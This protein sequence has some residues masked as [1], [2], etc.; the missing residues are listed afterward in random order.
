MENQF[1][2][3]FAIINS[4]YSEEVMDA[5]KEC[6]ATGGTI[7]NARGTANTEIEKFFGI[8]ISSEKEVVM[9]IIPKK[10]KE[11][12]LKVIYEKVGLDTPGQGIA[13]TLPVDDVVG[14]NK[15]I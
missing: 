3:V 1:E 10:I 11:A 7:L 6:G 5:V 4:G 8:S 12:V 14:I 13:F 9:I 2:M 15:N